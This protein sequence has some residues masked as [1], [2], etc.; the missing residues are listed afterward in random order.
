MRTQK[1]DSRMPI[2]QDGRLVAVKPEAPV[3][4]QNDRAPCTAAWVQAR[5]SHGCL[6]PTKALANP[7]GCAEAEEEG[8]AAGPCAA[9][10]QNMSPVHQ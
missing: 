9:R 5:P 7:G 6:G 8:R 10:A 3:R 2:G 4:T 1:P